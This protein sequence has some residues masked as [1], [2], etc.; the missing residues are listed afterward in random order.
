[1]KVIKTKEIL[2]REIGDL[3]KIAG[4]RLEHGGTEFRIGYESYTRSTG[5][6]LVDWRQAGTK[7]HFKPFLSMDVYM[8][9]KRADVNVLLNQIEERILEKLATA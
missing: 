2:G 1:M 7:Q 8:V 3:G 4:T 9:G 5:R 6:C